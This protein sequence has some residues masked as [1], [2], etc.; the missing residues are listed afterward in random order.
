MRQ[1]IVVAIALLADPALIIADEPTTALDVTIQAEIMDLLLELCESEETGLLLITHDLGVVAQVTEKVVVMYAG[2]IV[3]MGATNDIIENPRHPYTKGLI[4][5]I[6]GTRHPGERLHQIPG[7][8]PTLMNIPPGC[9][10]HPRC[11]IRG[12]ICTREVPKLEEIDGTGKIVA[13][14]MVS[15]KREVQ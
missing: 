7:V 14:H 1:R 9:S 11:T 4:K 15:G 5:A 13:C 12:E 3:E 8:M 10:F 2:N 6:P